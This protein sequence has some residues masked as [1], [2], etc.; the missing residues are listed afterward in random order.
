MAGDDDQRRGSPVRSR[1]PLN[2]RRLEV[3]ISR[4][5]ALLALAFGI[6]SVPALLAEASD[7]RAFLLVAAAALLYLSITVVL[8]AAIVQRGVTLAMCFV[9][10]VY[11]L[12]LV[13]W[14]FGVDHTAVGRDVSAWLYS[15]LISAAAC[16]A[17]GFSWR[18]A[19]SYVAVIPVVL[20]FERL[21]VTDGSIAIGKV[22]LESMY[23]V[24][25]GGAVIT[26]ASM[27]RYAAT[28][29]DAAQAA[30]LETYSVAVRHHAIEVERVQV[31]SI[32][33]DSILTA[34]LAAAR[35]N[36]E[37]TR[38]LAAS[39]ADGAIASL[40][41]SDLGHDVDDDAVSLRTIARRITDA[42]SQ[43]AT[44]FEVRTRDIAAR[45]LPATVAEALYSASVQA[46]VN[47][48]QHAGGGTRVKRWVLV[49]GRDLVGAEIEI[50]DTGTGF[51]PSVLP[52]SRLGVRVSIIERVSSVGGSVVIDSS[53]D[54]GT[55]VG[56][57]WP[58]DARQAVGASAGAPATKQ[59]ATKRAVS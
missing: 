44:P 35:A 2:R 45:S 5:T 24:I 3:I 53:L 19:T 10:A 18:I 55:V 26:I 12:T 16:A 34:L 57:Q 25:L 47:S 6:Q 51:D 21:Y 13:V 7:D 15:A 38:A 32:V 9:P 11:L 49:R 17:I 33:H 40:R 36:T 54:E 23:L 50:G 43:L 58:V 48:V 39:M 56:I 27:L 28:A 1:R 4:A 59:A 52:S 42:A 8:V 41:Y 31:D 37:Q 20:A 30:A 29:V 46:M 14:P 22:L